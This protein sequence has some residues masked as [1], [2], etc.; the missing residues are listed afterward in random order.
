MRF[1]V[2]TLHTDIDSAVV[3]R[4]WEGEYRIDPIYE[5]NSQFYAILVNLGI[6]ETDSEL[7]T[8]SLSGNEIDGFTV[9]L[10]PTA[11]AEFTVEN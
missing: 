10:G 2:Y 3:D 7:A 5:I 8:A 4:D 11:V 6:I 9:Y 1:Q